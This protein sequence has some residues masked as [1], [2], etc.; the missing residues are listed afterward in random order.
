VT[1]S[2]NTHWWD[3]HIQCEVVVTRVT[4]RVVSY[5][6]VDR[7]FAGTVPQWKFLDRFKPMPAQKKKGQ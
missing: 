2:P 1:G 6:A 4:I 3:D 7:P 5:T